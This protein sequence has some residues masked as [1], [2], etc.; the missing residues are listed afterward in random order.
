LYWV[1]LKNEIDKAL[2]KL[3]NSVNDTDETDDDMKK[4]NIKKN[5]KY[6]DKELTIV[7]LT[8]AIAAVNLLAL[9]FTLVKLDYDFLTENEYCLVN[10]VKLLSFDWPIIIEDCGA[11]LS[12]YSLLHLL[13][14]VSVIALVLI[15]VLLKKGKAFGK[16]CIF[17]MAV[18]FLTSLVYMINGIAAYSETSESYPLDNSGVSTIAY[19]PFI[20][21]CALSFTLIFVK[22]KMSDKFKF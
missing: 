13:I 16:M 21:I 3:Y 6:T 19:I 12:F 10:G 9:L 7:A 1:F 4:N 14:A 5:K 18:S 8:L 2:L 15:H 22:V 17:T 11:W 20:V